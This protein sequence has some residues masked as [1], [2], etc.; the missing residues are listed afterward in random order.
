MKNQAF[1]LYLFSRANGEAVHEASLD[2]QKGN[3]KGQIPWHC[4]VSVGPRVKRRLNKVHQHKK[5]NLVSSQ[6]HL[7][8][9]F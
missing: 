6:L 1:Y 5:K 3:L 9:R 4:A 2:V 8:Y 7:E